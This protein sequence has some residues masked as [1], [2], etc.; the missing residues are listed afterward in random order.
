LELCEIKT[1][2]KEIIIS[3]QGMKNFKSIPTA[4]VERVFIAGDPVGFIKIKNHQKFL[5]LVNSY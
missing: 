3:Y 4:Q 5:V 1:E 2:E